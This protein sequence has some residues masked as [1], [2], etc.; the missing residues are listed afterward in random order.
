MCTRPELKGPHSPFELML[1]DDDPMLRAF[2]VQ[3]TQH[4][5]FERCTSERQQVHLLKIWSDQHYPGIVSMQ[6]IAD[7]M[8]IAKSTVAWHLTKPFDCVTGCVSGC[9]GRPSVFDEET[10]ES[11]TEFILERFRQR[12]PCGYEDIRDFLFDKH[13]LVVN[14]VTLRSWV[15]RSLQFKSVDGVPME[16]RRV[17]CSETE[18]EEF[19]DKLEE[20][21]T[22][23]EIPSAF[24]CNLDEAGFDQFADRRRSKRIVPA[25]YSLKTVPTPISRSEK[26]A[27]LLAGICA[28]GYC[29]KPMLVLQRETLDCELLQLGYTNDK[30]CYGRSDTGYMSTELFL[31]WAENAFFPEIRDRRAKLDYAGPVLLLLDGFAV[32]HSEAF[33]RMC[34]EENVILLFYPA[35]SSDQLQPCDLGLFANQKRWQGNISLP[36]GMSKQTKQAI[37]VLDSLRIA[38]TPKNII[39]AFHKSGIVNR[40]DPKTGRLMAWVD[41]LCATRVR[42][43]DEDQALD[44][45]PQRRKRIPI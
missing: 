36:K 38:A 26:H 13:D 3:C 32:H 10:K 8:Q 17:Y 11:L 39:G 45:F 19:F 27:T 24:I 41:R 7:L 28:D 5:D 44:D 21:V 16:D 9:G 25:E 30:V 1:P 15:S 14:P 2:F 6:N 35:H 12:F 31:F 33:E 37:K 4:P 22:V 42:H 23:A 20:I 29:L 43:Y 40:Y 18:V 34:E